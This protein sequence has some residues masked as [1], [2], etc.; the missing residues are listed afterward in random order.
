MQKFFL[1]TG[2]LLISRLLSAQTK[3]TLPVLAEVIVKGYENNRRLS[4]VAASVYRLNLNDHPVLQSN[5]LVAALNTVPGVRMEERSPGSYRLSVRGS[6]LRSPFGVRNV[7]IYWNDIPFTDA[8]G[9]SYLNL[10]DVNSIQKIEILNGP[11]GSVYGAGTGGTLLL[12]GE[13]PTGIHP[14]HA[15]ALRLVGGSYGLLQQNMEWKSGNSAFQSAL[16]QSHQQSDGY[17]DNSRM[18]RDVLQWS[19]RWFINPRQTLEWIT[20]AA[21]LYYQT[22]GG[23]TEQQFA[24]NPKQARAA[25]PVLPGAIMQRAAVYNK[26]LFSGITHTLRM[27]KHWQQVTSITGMF[28]RFKNPF[29]TNYEKRQENG[30]GIRSKFVWRGQLAAMPLQWTAGGE[31]QQSFAGIDNYNNNAG[32]PGNIQNLDKVTAIQS[33]AFLQAN[34]DIT[35]QLLLSAGLS[36]N[37][38]IFRYIRTSAIPFTPERRKQFT[39]VSLPRFSLIY[40]FAGD[41]SAFAQVSKGYSPPTIAELRPSEGSFYTNLQPEY[42][43]NYELGLKRYGLGKQLQFS[44][45][46]YRFQLEDAIVR[47]VAAGGAEFFVNAG[48]T[49][50]Q[51]IEAGVDYSCWNNAVDRT[52]TSLSFYTRATLSR[53]RFDNYTVTTSNYSGNALTG[54]PAQVLVCGMDMAIHTR[55]TVG[56]IFNYT[57]KLPLTDANDA[58]AADYRLLQ[59]RAG[60][61]GYLG[62]CKYELF[63]AGDNLLNQS[64]SLGNDIN[65]AGKRY[66]NP[67]PQRNF[68]VGMILSN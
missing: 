56:M 41:I 8:G 35:P 12:S 2:L 20:L 53:H 55:L 68:S 67:A 51:G 47:R 58:Y 6:L 14:K 38:Y 61:K 13:V 1:L 37:Q 33:F 19:G 4:E 44:I 18:R 3:D 25:T 63:V 30:G 50:Q 21:D 66:F 39:P 49:I 54:V 32:T 40:K 62:K 48:G 34:L 26:T 64:Y 10:L 43:W 16:V 22:P 9:N 23:L 29:I 11:S 17:R 46:A 57:A 27:S 59:A 24:A 15:L 28:T 65:A 31:W 7:K 36:Y 52:I 60:Y 45:S 5:S 42:G